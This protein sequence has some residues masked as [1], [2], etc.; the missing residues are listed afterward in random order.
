MRLDT[1]SWQL[2]YSHWVHTYPRRGR[3]WTESLKGI[4]F[5]KRF[6]GLFG[7]YTGTRNEELHLSVAGRSH[8]IMV[9]LIR[10]TEKQS[11]HFHLLKLSHCRTIHLLFS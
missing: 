7:A 5:G 9:S 6:K 8:H 11:A 2:P 4:T 1:C 10:T 3:F